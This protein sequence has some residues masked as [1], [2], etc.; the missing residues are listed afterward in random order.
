M[1]C[2]YIYILCNLI[3]NYYELCQNV[4][5]EIPTNTLQQKKKKI[6]MLNIHCLKL[7]LNQLV[8]FQGILGHDTGRKPDIWLKDHSTPFV[9]R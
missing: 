7:K 8:L 6:I 5:E 3:S 4:N 1:L 9:F 2:D